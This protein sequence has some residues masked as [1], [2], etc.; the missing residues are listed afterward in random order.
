MYGIFTYIYPKNDPNVGK[1]SIHGAPGRLTPSQAT[2]FWVKWSCMLF[3]E[4]R[5]PSGY[6][7]HSCG[8]HGSFTEDFPTKKTSIYKG[9]SMAM[10]V[11]T[12]WYPPKKNIT[13]PR[14]Q[15]SKPLPVGH[16]EHGCMSELHLEHVMQRRDLESTR[17][18]DL[19][20][21]P[22]WRV[23]YLQNAFLKLWLKLLA[24]HIYKLRL[25]SH[26]IKWWGKHR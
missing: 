16:G 8:S 19:P 21:W 20:A 7:L 5:V 15:D 11:I 23:C 14:L 6:L 24:P 22:W 26:S 9:F 2:H 1:Y 18:C 3:C 17:R 13:I 4:N 12:R 25:C 10:L